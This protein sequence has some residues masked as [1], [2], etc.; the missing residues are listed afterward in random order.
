MHCLLILAR[1]HD[2][3]CL[4]NENEKWLVPKIDLTSIKPQKRKIKESSW[5]NIR[6]NIVTDFITGALE[7]NLKCKSVGQTASWSRGTFKCAQEDILNESR[8][9]NFIQTLDNVKVYLQKLLKVIPFSGSITMATAASNSFSYSPLKSYTGYDLVLAV[10]LRNFETYGPLA[11]AGP[12]SYEQ[13]YHR[14][15]S[16]IIYL[17]AKEVPNSV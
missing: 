8:K 10:V 11:M 16:G 17:N 6:I 7:D 14:P 15:I 9:A 13:I 1:S 5:Q 2:F 4:H 3:K 12:T